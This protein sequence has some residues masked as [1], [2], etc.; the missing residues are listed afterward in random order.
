[1]R[2]LV[3]LTTVVAA[4]GVGA[5]SATAAPDPFAQAFRLCERQGGDFGTNPLGYSCGVPGVL[6][7]RDLVQAA[8][9]CNRNG[10]GFLNLS[11]N[12]YGCT[13]I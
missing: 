9:V 10:G 12:V 6:T 11:S 4:M 3:A 8:R 5:T 7:D 1:M 2:R 13:F